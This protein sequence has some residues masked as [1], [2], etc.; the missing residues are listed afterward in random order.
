MQYWIQSAPFCLSNQIRRKTRKSRTNFCKS[1]IFACGSRGDA[2]G[3][4][5]AEEGTAHIGRFHAISQGIG[6][7]VFNIYEQLWVNFPTYPTTHASEECKIYARFCLFPCAFK[8]AKCP[9]HPQILPTASS[10]YVLSKLPLRNPC[11][12]AVKTNKVGWP[13]NRNNETTNSGASRPR[14]PAVPPSLIWLILIL[15]FLPFPQ[16]VPRLLTNYAFSKLI[17]QFPLV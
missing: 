10:S 11:R 3:W 4:E 2:V 9:C 1:K 17:R 7:L 8:Y 16:I 5:L 14:S 6:M 13:I 15:S 12:P